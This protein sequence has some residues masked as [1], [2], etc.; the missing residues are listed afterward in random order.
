MLKELLE[1]KKAKSRVF[2]VL[3]LNNG[4]SQEVEVQESNK[5]DFLKVQE[6]LKQGGSVFITSKNSQKLNIPKENKKAHR[7]KN[8]MKT[9]RAFY[10]DHV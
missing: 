5:I 6:H 9:V 1:V 3:L 8:K 4:A 7:N 2:Q 10:F